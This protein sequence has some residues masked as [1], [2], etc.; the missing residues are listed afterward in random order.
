MESP[1]GHDEERPLRKLPVIGGAILGF[2][3][4]WVLLTIA[5]L[6]LYG[7]QVTGFLEWLVP[8]VALFALP[9]VLGLLL[10][11]ERTRR[12]GAGALLGLAIGSIT[13]A[14]VCAGFVGINSL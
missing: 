13:G 4:T 3:S 8:A 14:G 5:I 9:V 12:W 2:I 6:V 10:V 11:P 1:T 7:T